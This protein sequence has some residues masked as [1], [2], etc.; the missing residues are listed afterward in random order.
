MKILFA[1]LLSTLVMVSS[2]SAGDKKNTAETQASTSNTQ[3]SIRHLKLRAHA[4]TPPPN[5][6]SAN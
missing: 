3:T 5:Y 1:L 4:V 2:A 6:S